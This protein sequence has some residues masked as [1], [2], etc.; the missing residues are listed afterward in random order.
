VKMDAVISEKRA[1]SPRLEVA[2]DDME[3]TI[4]V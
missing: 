3:T 2:G 4:V 1:C